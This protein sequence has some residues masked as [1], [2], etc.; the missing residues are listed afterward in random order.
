MERQYKKWNFPAVLPI[1][2][3]PTSIPF[4]VDP[5]IGQSDPRE[6]TG[7][8]PLSAN[9][10]NQKALLMDMFVVPCGGTYLFVPSI[11]LLRNF[12]KH[13]STWS[14]EGQIL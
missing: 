2:V 14:L 11:N 8:D 10:P 9:D 3:S 1:C 7:Y 13:L 12:S 4:S 6:M 5:I